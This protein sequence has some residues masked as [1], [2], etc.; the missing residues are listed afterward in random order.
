MT[1]KNLGQL[2]LFGIIIAFC[3]AMSIIEK[4][5]KERKYKYCNNQYGCV[6]E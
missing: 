1:E 3:W 2:M 4:S 5:D 6:C